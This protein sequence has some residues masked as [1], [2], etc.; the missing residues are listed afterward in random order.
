MIL[1]R[2]SFF[3]VFTSDHILIR[4]KPDRDIAICAKR[5]A[6]KGVDI[7]AASQERPRSLVWP[8]NREVDL[9]IFV[10]IPGNSFISGLSKLSSKGRPFE[11]LKKNQKPLEGLKLPDPH[12][13]ICQNRRQP[14]CLRFVQMFRCE[15]CSCR[16]SLFIARAIFV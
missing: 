5:E 2:E 10:V 6:E 1:V 7:V 16:L 3:F 9:S 12:R 4:I 11:R 14:S 8:E 13:C 15:P